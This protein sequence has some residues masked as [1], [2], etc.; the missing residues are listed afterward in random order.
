MRLLQL[1]YVTPGFPA[2]PS[3]PYWE[4]C[5]YTV[6]CCCDGSI[7]CRMEWS[8]NY[9]LMLKYIDVILEPKRKQKKKNLL[10]NVLE[11][12]SSL[13]RSWLL[14]IRVFTFGQWSCA[15]L[16]GSCTSP[17]VYVCVCA[18]LDAQTTIYNA[19]MYD[20][21][22]TRLFIWW[23]GEWSARGSS[24]LLLHIGLSLSQKV[25]RC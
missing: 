2:H 4:Y 11:P 19:R 7:I 6:T 21:L 20:L 10:L 13:T 12:S 5:V 1:N 25:R 14:E 3:L 23:R 18:C 24:S 17:C 22:M 8:H 15:R 9:L 16:W